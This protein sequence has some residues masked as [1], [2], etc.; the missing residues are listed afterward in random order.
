M[1][2][3]RSEVMSDGEEFYLR[4][5]LRDVVR[6]LITLDSSLRELSK[7]L[8]HHGD[9]KRQAS[10]SPRLAKKSNLGT[11]R[12]IPAGERESRRLRPS[13]R[14]PWVDPR[15]SPGRQQ[16]R[17]QRKVGSVMPRDEHDLSSRDR[18]AATPSSSGGSP[19]PA[20]SREPFPRRATHDRPAI[21]RRAAAGCGPRRARAR[22]VRDL[23]SLGWTRAR[24]DRSARTT[25][26]GGHEDGGPLSSD[27]SMVSPAPSAHGSV[28]QRAGSPAVGCTCAWQP[29]RHPARSS[30]VRP[31]SA[32]CV[33]SSSK[34]WGALRITSMTWSAINS[35]QLPAMTVSAFPVSGSAQPA[36]S[37]MHPPLPSRSASHLTRTGSRP[38][39]PGASPPSPPETVV[40]G[41]SAALRDCTPRMSK[42]R[43]SRAKPFGCASCLKPWRDGRHVVCVKAIG[44]LCVVRRQPPFSR[45]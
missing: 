37:G 3:R 29:C 43:W 22:W 10:K 1:T 18:C 21:G 14:V 8:S 23:S 13:P 44:R 39:V 36:S 40:L 25:P 27:T 41:I 42:P 31:C 45:W 16:R 4:R 26:I 28:V 2:N 24:G 38:R 19:R 17:K 5:L 9:L 7:A 20:R 6:Q 34:L 35:S 32:S 11:T 15:G 33:P 30:C 12:P